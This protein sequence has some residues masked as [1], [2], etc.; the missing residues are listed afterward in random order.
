MSASRKQ[1]GKE[2][3]PAPDTLI[4][5]MRTIHIGI[6]LGIALMFFKQCGGRRGKDLPIIGTNARIGEMDDS[7]EYKWRENFVQQLDKFWTARTGVGAAKVYFSKDEE[8]TSDVEAAVAGEAGKRKTMSGEN[9]LLSLWWLIS[10]NNIYDKKRNAKAQNKTKIVA[11]DIV[12]DYGDDDVDSQ[13]S[14]EGGGDGTRSVFS[15]FADLRE[16]ISA[17]GRTARTALWQH[18]AI[19]N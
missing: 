10:V 13:Q 6:F 16:E 9:V 15:K 3:V 1:N 17:A 7:E 11:D 8:P 4:Q 18:Q 14:E 12:K 5:E 2:H 19:R